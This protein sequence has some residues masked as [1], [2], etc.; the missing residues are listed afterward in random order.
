[1]TLKLTELSVTSPSEG[2]GF[3]GAASGATYPQPQAAPARPCTAC[4]LCLNFDGEAVSVY[5]N[6]FHHLD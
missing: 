6:R 2:S 5:G 3:G 1:M 4:C